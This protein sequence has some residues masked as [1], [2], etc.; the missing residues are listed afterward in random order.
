[1]TEKNGKPKIVVLGGGNGTSRLLKA[2][3]PWLQAGKIDSLYALVN[4]ADDGGSTGKLRAQYDVGGIGDLTNS[5]LALSTLWGDIR[6][7][8]LLKALTYRFEEGDF[9]GHTLRNILLTVFEL[10]AGD[11]DSAL[12]IMARLIQIPKFTGVIPLTLRPLTQQ[13]VV[14]E[15]ILGEGQH[16]I[17]WNVDMQADAAWK[18]GDVKIAFKE[19]EVELNPR[20]ATALNEAT[21]IIIAPGHTVGTILPTLATPGLQ[22]AVQQSAAHITIVMT[23]LTTPKQTTGWSGEDFVRVYESYLGR[24]ADA[25]IGNTGKPDISLVG[26]QG[27]VEFGDESHPYALITEDVAQ[28]LSTTQHSAD[29]VPRPIVVHDSQ[30]MKKVFAHLLSIE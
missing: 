8:E 10:S 22:A 3:L 2:L 30:R 9:K 12:S 4:M 23:L 19:K 16:F 20:A 26:G 27:W 14:G 1:M 5:M 21:H 25:V 17:S 28:V 18:P 29:T 7:E 11:I 6:G 24:A 13:V 15:K